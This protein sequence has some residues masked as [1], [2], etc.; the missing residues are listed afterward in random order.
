MTFWVMKFL[1][2]EHWKPYLHHYVK[3]NQQLKLFQQPSS[4]P[5]PPMVLVFPHPSPLVMTER[6]FGTMFLC[7]RLRHLSVTIEEA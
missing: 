1:L 4:P 5:P 3:M 2:F 7:N 6:L